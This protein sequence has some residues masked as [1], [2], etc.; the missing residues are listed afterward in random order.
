VEAAAL[1]GDDGA[2]RR[3]REEESAR[4]EEAAHEKEAVCGEAATRKGDG[5]ARGETAAVRVR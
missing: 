5:G 2:G 4:G 3:Q 1:K